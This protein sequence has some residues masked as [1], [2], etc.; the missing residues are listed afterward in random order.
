MHIQCL[1]SSRYTISKRELLNTRSLFINTFFTGIR[2]WK[3]YYFIAKISSY[4]KFWW[5]LAKNTQSDLSFQNSIVQERTKGYQDVKYISSEP[6]IFNGFFRKFC[7]CNVS[8][9][10][11]KRLAVQTGVKKIYNLEQI[12]NVFF[13]IEQPLKS[14]YTRGHKNCHATWL[15]SEKSCSH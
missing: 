12:K 8:R 13:K 3:W 9:E 5:C 15:T 6:V 1:I 2:F 7:F 10:T 14:V 4:F 11:Y